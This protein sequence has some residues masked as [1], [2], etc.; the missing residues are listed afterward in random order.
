MGFMVLKMTGL[1]SL[2]QTKNRF[3]KICNEPRDIKQ[4]V[5]K[6]RSP[7][8][9]F[10][11]WDILVNISGPGAYFS[12]PMPYHKNYYQAYWKVHFSIFQ[13]TL[14]CMCVCEFV[15]LC[16]YPPNCTPALPLLQ[17]T[18]RTKLLRL[19]A[20]FLA[21]S[22]ARFFQLHSFFHE[23][24]SKKKCIALKYATECEIYISLL[25]WKWPVL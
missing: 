21:D 22:V 15:C 12:K 3:W 1:G 5:P 2:F 20:S 14:V 9:T 6:F 11:F 18:N 16:G 23:N 4:F 7:N 8:Q 19:S 13:H 24:I 10:I 25:S 17:G